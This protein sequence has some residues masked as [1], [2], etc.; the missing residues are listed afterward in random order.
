MFDL[1]G[2]GLLWKMLKRMKI[3]SNVFMCF[4]VQELFIPLIEN[5]LEFV[6]KRKLLF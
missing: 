6:F 2:G 1:H 5:G 4:R 3:L